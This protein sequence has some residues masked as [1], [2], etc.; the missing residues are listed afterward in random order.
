MHADV[1]TCRGYNPEGVRMRTCTHGLRGEAVL[2]C[3]Q[4]TAKVRRPGIAFKGARAHACRR[5]RGQARHW[6]KQV[7]G[8]VAITLGRVRAR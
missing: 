2:G 1:G 7:H 5:E 6:I 3:M 8:A 4:C